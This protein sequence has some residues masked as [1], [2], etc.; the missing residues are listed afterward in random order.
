MKREAG[1][2]TEHSPPSTPRRR[3]RL[4]RKA[5]GTVLVV[6]GLALVAWTVVVWRWQDPFTSAYTQVQQHRL[7]S[8]YARQLAEYRP[9]PA[10][11]RPRPPSRHEKLVAELKAIKVE[12][13][14]YRVHARR[15][16][17]IGRIRIP[18]LGL[19]MILV[20]GTDHDSLKRGPGRDPRAYMPGEGQLVYIAGHRTTYSAPFADIE[21]LRRGDRVTLQTPYAT[22]EYRIVRHVIV[23]S[24]ALY[25]LRSHGSEL[26]ALQACHPRFFATHRY[27]AYARPIR[28]IPRGGRPL[29]VA[30]LAADRKKS[31]RRG[32]SSLVATTHG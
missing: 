9:P 5:L 10:P 32:S 7:A 26:L 28:V 13:R 16:D 11:P 20:N 17:P 30:R 6:V 29:D 2:T 18:R 27:I 24:N 22:F 19:N 25:V 21:T 8:G 23:P 3:R 4:L 12:A 14:S 1:G 15:G 31:H